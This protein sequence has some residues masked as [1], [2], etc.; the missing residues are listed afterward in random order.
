MRHFLFCVSLY[1]ASP[2]AQ[3]GHCAVVHGRDM[4]NPW[5]DGAHGGDRKGQALLDVSRPGGAARRMSCTSR[6]A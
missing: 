6:N 2:T 1:D 4:T 3:Q 5:L